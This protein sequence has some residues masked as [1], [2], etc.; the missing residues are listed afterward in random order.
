MRIEGVPEGWK[1]VAI[2]VPLKG[3]HV[4]GNLG[5]VLEVDGHCW[6]VFPVVRKQFENVQSFDRVLTQDEIAFLASHRQA[7]LEPKYIPWTM[8]TCPVGA[9]VTIA[10]GTRHLITDAY[11]NVC[12]MDC[13][14]WRYDG[15]LE[16]SKFRCNGEPC[17]TKVEP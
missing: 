10:D 9:I 17:G 5:T 1:L 11:T 7:K 4:I 2:R 16:K 13:G 12:R 15:L 3:E 8:E 6:S 14:V